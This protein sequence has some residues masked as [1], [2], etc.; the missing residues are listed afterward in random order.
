[1]SELVIHYQ[2]DALVVAEKP[3]GLLVHRSSIDARERRAMVQMLRD[4]IGAHVHPVHRLDKATSGLVLFALDT[5]VARNL[6]EQFASG[7]VKKVYK[8]IVRGHVVGD[9]VINHALRDEVDHRGQRIK[10]GIVREADTHLEVLSHWTVPL[11][12]DRYPEGR[13]SMVRLS[14]RTGRF[15]QLRRHMKHISHPIIGDVRYGKGTHNRFFAEQLGLSRLWL[16]AESLEL[17][18]PNTGRLLRVDTGV[19]ADFGRCLE[20]FA[21]HAEFGRK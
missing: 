11:P 13:Y 14:P 18:H 7:S 2:D 6:S 3:S 15:R 10:G 21:S 8:A 1:L 20:W 16:H 4:Q 12:V 9:R 17:S 5:E 19:A